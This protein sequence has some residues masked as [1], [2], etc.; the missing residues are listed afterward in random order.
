MIRTESF[1]NQLQ[2]EKK[3]AV[4]NLTKTIFKMHFYFCHFIQI[5]P[6]MKRMIN[7]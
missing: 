5:T 6:V 7:V 3:N 2:F 4:K 1:L